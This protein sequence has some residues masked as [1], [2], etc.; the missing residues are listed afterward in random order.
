MTACRGCLYHR[1]IH[2]E[3]RFCTKCHEMLRKGFPEAAIKA[4]R[5]EIPL[6]RERIALMEKER[7]RAIRTAPEATDEIELSD[8]RIGLS[9][10][11]YPPEQVT[12]YTTLPDTIGDGNTIG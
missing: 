2:R 7:L 12:I 6:Y 5:R 9:V 10:M 11:G 3:T 8:D 4:I 1:P